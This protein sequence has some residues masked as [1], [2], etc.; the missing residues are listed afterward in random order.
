MRYSLAGDALGI[1][2]PVARCTYAKATGG[3]ELVLL[4]GVFI[5]PGKQRRFFLNYIDNHVSFLELVK[6]G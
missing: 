1:A 4:L 2:P 5:S 6:L 3:R